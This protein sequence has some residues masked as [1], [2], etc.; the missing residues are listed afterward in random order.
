MKT[1]CIVIAWFLA[2][3]IARAGEPQIPKAGLILDLNA[4]KD[5]ELADG[6]VVG[7]RNQID[8]PARDFKATW[9]EGRPALRKSLEPLH[10]H[11]SISFHHQA[12]QNT[13]EDAFDR[14]ITG[15]GY[16]WA[17]VMCAYK[18]QMQ[19]QD[20]N[21]IFGNLKNGSEYEGIWAN[22]NDDNS[23]WI[24]SR[25]GRTFGR[26]NADNPKVQGPKLEA[27]RYY[28]LAG[29]MAAGTNTVPVELFINETKPVA[30]L[31]FPVNPKANSSKM[32]IGQERDARNH[33]GKEAF[34]GE[35]ARLLIWDRPLA[36]GELA[37]SFLAL[38]ADY[39]IK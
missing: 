20:V 1:Q 34:D 11:N 5:V 15:G 39:A 17:L 16:T 12:L 32:A 25:N 13:D 21:S 24:G 22:L 27:Y 37:E 26:W 7:W 3:L 35:I 33:P 10:G 18:Q 2:A 14:L 9:P 6:K 23:P 4:D 31:P 8:F 28:I 36:D 38:K 30:S 19:L 29:R